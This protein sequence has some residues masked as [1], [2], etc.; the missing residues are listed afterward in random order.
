MSKRRNNEA[1]ESGRRLISDLID[2]YTDNHEFRDVYVE[3]AQDQLRV[4]W[5]LQQHH[6]RNVAVYEIESVHIPMETLLKYDLEDGQKGRVVALALELEGKIPSPAQATCVGDSDYDILLERKYAAASLVLTEY[7]CHEMYAFN[8]QTVD[9][10][11]AFSAGVCNVS[12][13][14]LLD[15]TT[16]IMVDLHVL[17][18][19]NQSLKWGM[20]WVDIDKDI[21]FSKKNLSFDSDNYVKRYLLRN[22][23]LGQ[24]EEFKSRAVELRRLKKDDYRYHVSKKDVFVVLAEYLPHVCQDASWHKPNI[25]ANSLVGCVELKQLEQARIYQEILARVKA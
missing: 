24:V 13:D 23:R 17:R 20:K 14:E 6:I 22:G 5:F 16:P 7:S 15:T 8:K 19:T 2:H 1:D 10:F 9:K 11:L 25:I 21:S 12:A 3:G 18:A 4:Q